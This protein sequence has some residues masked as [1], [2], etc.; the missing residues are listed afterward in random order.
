MY[1]SWL[2]SSWH[3][4]RYLHVIGD[5]WTRIPS[6]RHGCSLD[7][8]WNI[9]GTL[10][11]STVWITCSFFRVLNKKFK[12][13][14]VLWLSSFISKIK[15]K[16]TRGCSSVK[17]VSLLVV[18]GGWCSSFLTPFCLFNIKYGNKFSNKTHQSYKNWIS[19]LLGCFEPNDVK[20]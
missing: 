3:D 16:E 14:F 20:I 9:F 18:F 6:P 8:N 11:G 2:W 19:K 17:S 5:G 15:S 13:R 1:H 12:F 10:C 7:V 4:V